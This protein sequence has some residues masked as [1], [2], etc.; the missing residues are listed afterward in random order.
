MSGRAAGGRGRRSALY[1]VDLAFSSA[2]SLGAFLAFL[3]DA[4]AAGAVSLDWAMA[5]WQRRAVLLRE[6]VNRAVA[7]V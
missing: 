3:R 6:E 4:G 1:D 5:L 2:L 7:R